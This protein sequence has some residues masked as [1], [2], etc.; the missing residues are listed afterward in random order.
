MMKWRNRKF[1]LLLALFMLGMIAWGV[2]S[3]LN[4]YA[5]MSPIAASLL[6]ITPWLCGYAFFALLPLYLLWRVFF[7]K[8]WES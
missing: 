5:Q 8:N 1:V 6:D 3:T 2:L 4:R 7:N